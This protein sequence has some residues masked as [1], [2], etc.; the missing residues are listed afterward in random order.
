MVI[1]IIMGCGIYR[2]LNVV[3]NKS[4]VGSSINMSSRK[5]KHF[6]MLSNGTHDNKYLQ[7][8]FDKYGYNHFVFEILEECTYSN[9][10][11]RENFYIN[12][13]NS[14]NLSLGYNLSL[15]NEFRR[16]TYNEEVKVS[17]SKYNLKK[18]NN[19]TKYSLTN[20]L[21]NEIFIFDTLVEGANYLISNGFSNGNPRNVRQKISYALRGKKVNNGASGSIRKTIYNHKFEIINQ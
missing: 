19:F 18:N 13:F 9:L 3:N 12:K 1:F 20:I 8:S 14:N 4:Y 6:W 16:N 2:I 15:V 11:D 5:Y 7:K 17:L 21:S 10:I